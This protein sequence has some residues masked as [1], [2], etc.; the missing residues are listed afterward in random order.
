MA[1]ESAQI[2]AQIESVRARLE[3]NLD[4]FEPLVARRLHRGKRLAQVGAIAGIVLVV[5]LIVPGSKLRHRRRAHT[6]GGYCSR[7]RGKLRRR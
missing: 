6:R 7:C 1:K 3:E 4:Q 2:R 5:A